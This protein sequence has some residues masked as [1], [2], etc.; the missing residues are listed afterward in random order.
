MESARADILYGTPCSDGKVR[1]EL[2]VVDTPDACPDT[3]GKIVVAKMTDPGW[4]FI[5]AGAAGLVV[6]KGSLLSHTA[7]ISRELGKP[8]AVGVEN[9][10]SLLRSGDFAE[11]DGNAGTVTVIER[12]KS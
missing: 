6:E 9:A 5:I 12:S 7:I 8:C 1:G 4:V 2:L 10:A 3:L 11:L